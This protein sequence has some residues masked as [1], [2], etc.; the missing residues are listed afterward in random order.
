MKITIA[1]VVAVALAA[2]C[3][4]PLLTTLQDAVMPPGQRL[5]AA[6]PSEEGTAIAQFALG[7]CACA[8]LATAVA[9]RLHRYPLTTR[10]ALVLLPMF[11]AALFAAS[12][13]SVQYRDA[14]SAAGT[15]GFRPALPLRQAALHLIPWSGFA[16]GLISVL[17]ALIASRRATSQQ[18]AP[19]R[20]APAPSQG[21]SGVTETPPP[22]S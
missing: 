8:A 11:I 5:A 7:L 19:P 3:S 1:I 14:A 4:R 22:A 9:F 21:S 16:A 2:I 18:A 10:L 20:R 15:F 13:R 6:G 12:L 17:V